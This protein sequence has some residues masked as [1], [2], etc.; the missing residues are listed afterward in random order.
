M[1]LPDGATIRDLFVQLKLHQSMQSNILESKL[2]DVFEV[3]VNGV[4]EANYE[5][6]LLDGDKVVMFPPMSGG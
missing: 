1:D 4:S 5:R 2:S 3:T 6:E